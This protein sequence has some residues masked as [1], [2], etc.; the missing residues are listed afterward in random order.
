LHTL[1]R[2]SRSCAI[3]TCSVGFKRQRKL[4]NDAKVPLLSFLVNFIPFMEHIFANIFWKKPSPSE[5]QFDDHN[6]VNFRKYHLYAC[7]RFANPL[8]RQFGYTLIKRLLE[9]EWGELEGDYKKLMRLSIPVLIMW[10]GED[11]IVPYC[12]DGLENVFGLW[13]GKGSVENI[14][15]KDAQHMYCVEHPVDCSKYIENFWERVSRCS[16]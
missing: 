2:I 9:M 15:V 5:A 8:Q 11:K 13:E 14:I 12:K 10:G 4:L 3:V 7:E 1:T 16:V 6:S